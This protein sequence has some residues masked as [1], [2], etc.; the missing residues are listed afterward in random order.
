M[1][2]PRRVAA[3]ALLVLLAACAGN[4]GPGEPGYPFNLSGEYTGEFNVE[5]MAIP[6]LMTLATA[7]GGVV[8]GSFTVAQMGITG[9]VDGTLAGDQ[10]A[11]RATYF[12][13]ESSCNGTA[14]SSATVGE[15]GA[16]LSGPLSVN[17]CG[18]TMSGSFS[19]RR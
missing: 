8:T 3:S 7:S 5:G 1:N 16:T 17:E 13:P 12:N 6:A 18:Q 19:F 9:K 15:G 10:L 14:E 4:P 2:R 11:F